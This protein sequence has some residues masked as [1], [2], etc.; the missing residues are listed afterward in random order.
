MRRNTSK[1]AKPYDIDVSVE[2]SIN[3]AHDPGSKHVEP[4]QVKTDTPGEY[5]DGD[6]HVIGQEEMGKEDCNGDPAPV[7]EQVCNGKS[8]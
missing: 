8:G 2:Q 7:S 3:G 5:D 6:K 4:G 1:V